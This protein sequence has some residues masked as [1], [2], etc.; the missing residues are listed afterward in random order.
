MV[1]RLVSQPT[2]HSVELRPLPMLF[3]LTCGYYQGRTIV[4][5]ED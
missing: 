1:S 5:T 4:D 3:A 2:V